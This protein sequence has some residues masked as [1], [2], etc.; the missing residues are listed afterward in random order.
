LARRDDGAEFGTALQLV[1]CGLRRWWWS[2]R[3][4]PRLEYVEL[5]ETLVN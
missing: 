2:G 4:K 1:G 3:A 5:T